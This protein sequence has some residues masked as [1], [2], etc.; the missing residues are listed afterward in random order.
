VLSLG[1]FGENASK[2]PW[3]GGD[4]VVIVGM[5]TQSQYYCGTGPLFRWSAIPTRIRVNMWI[6]WYMNAQAAARFGIADRRNS[7]PKSLPR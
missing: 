3:H 1:E 4:T 5:G 7:G 6:V 2:C